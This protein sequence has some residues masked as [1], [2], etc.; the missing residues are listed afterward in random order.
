MESKKERFNRL[1]E[2]RTSKVIEYLASLS[3][4]SSK[5]NYDYSEYEIRQIFKAIDEQ[6]K[7]TKLSFKDHDKHHSFKLKSK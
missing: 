6:L 2:Q 4:L 3:K 1:A 5:K 7:L